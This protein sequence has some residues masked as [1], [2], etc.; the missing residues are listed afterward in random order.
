MR[1]MREGTDIARIA[2]ED[3]RRQTQAPARVPRGGAMKR[4]VMIAS[5]AQGEMGAGVTGDR[6]RH[7]GETE[8]IGTEG[9]VG[10]HTPARADRDHLTAVRLRHIAVGAMTPAG[11]ISVRMSAK[12]ATASL[13]H[14]PQKTPPTM[15]T[16]KPSAQPNS[17][18]CS[19][20]RQNWNQTAKPVSPSSKRRKRSS[21]RRTT[22]SGR[23]KAS[24]S[25]VCGRRRRAWML[26][27]G[28]RIQVGGWRR[29]RHP[30][31]RR[32]GIWRGG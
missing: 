17:Q 11:I 23:R 8:M 18:P 30:L 3:D 6:V 10:G 1:T 27:G 14:R 9:I 7:P 25:A 15:Q 29:T 13:T 4:I 2:T 22:R 21:A 19:P 32:R 20:A 16:K 26:R 31:R 24:S 12:L 28:C 5:T